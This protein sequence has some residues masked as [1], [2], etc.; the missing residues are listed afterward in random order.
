M[1]F[2][3]VASPPNEMGCYIQLI[4]RHLPLLLTLPIAGLGPNTHATGGPRADPRN[5]DWPGR[6]MDGSPRVRIRPQMVIGSY[7]R[8]IDKGL[9]LASRCPSCMA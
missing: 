5:H 6:N 9:D 7:R 3:H 2:S 1:R 4:D 8:D